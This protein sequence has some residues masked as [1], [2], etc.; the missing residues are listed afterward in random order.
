MRKER[1]K[2]KNKKKKK[3]V[4]KR[5]ENQNNKSPSSER[6]SV[7]EIFASSIDAIGVQCSD[8]EG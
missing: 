2:S 1:K 8:E 7:S 5:K 6:G 4:K 3:E